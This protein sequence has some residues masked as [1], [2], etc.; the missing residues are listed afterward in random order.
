M[1]D[2]CFGFSVYMRLADRGRFRGFFS[3]GFLLKDSSSGT[4]GSLVKGG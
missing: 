4:A 2:A 3:R 1:G